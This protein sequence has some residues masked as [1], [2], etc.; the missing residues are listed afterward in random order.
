MNDL[1]FFTNEAGQALGDRFNKIIKSNTKDFDV[2]VGYFRTSGFYQLYEALENVEKI[3]ILVGINVDNETLILNNIVTDNGRM[4]L[5]PKEV[6]K[7]T[8]ES[9]KNE[10]EIFE[11]ISQKIELT[12]EEKEK[13]KLEIKN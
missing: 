2:L 3:R 4:I 11:F 1:T 5:S 7:F 6:K 8:S 13:I 10:V 12:Q 9:I